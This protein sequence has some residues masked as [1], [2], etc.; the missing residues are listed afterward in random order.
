MPPSESS[1]AFPTRQTCETS[2][3]FLP[4]G[5]AGIVQ[6]RQ[7]TRRAAQGGD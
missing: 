7:E 6:L 5:I 2:D 3:G 1:D 4:C